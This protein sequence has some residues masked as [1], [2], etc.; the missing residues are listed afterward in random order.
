MT[1]DTL[2]TRLLA[3]LDEELPAAIELRHTLHANPEL[4]G[5]EH[6]TGQ[7]I[8]DALD[9][10]QLT[11]VAGTGLLGRVEGVG[12]RSV[13]VRAEL[14]GLPIQEATLAPF[15]ASNGYMHACGHDVH[16]AAL[17]AL[18]RAARR[19]PELPATLVALFQ[20]SEEAIPSGALG[21]V[22]SNALRALR[23]GAMV[24][25][26]VHPGLPWGKTAVT[27]GV[28]NAS[29]DNFRIRIKGSTGHAAYPHLARDPIVAL[30]QVIVSLQQIVSRRLDPMTNAVITIGWIKAGSAN[31]VIPETAEAG[32][33]LRTLQPAIRS[34]LQSLVTTT[35][36]QTARAHGC[37]AAITFEE[38]EPSLVNDQT[39]ADSVGRLVNQVG[40]ARGAEMRSCGADDFAYFAEVA[41]TLMMFVGVR[42]GRSVPLH[43]P[44]FLPPD[45][46][47]AEVARAQL[48]AYL[49][50]CMRIAK[51][52]ARE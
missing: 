43:H 16:M 6:A 31:N 47:V 20:P 33:T 12:S 19:V 29:A 5:A 11:S 2:M 36:R 10:V 17:T 42:R 8:A 9:P 41:P 1:E 27:A 46:A 32:G 25:V 51:F 26:H 38:G 49:G 34:Q 21:V 44:R 7:A 3:A 13:V 14:D 23:M 35:A 50:G 15:A 40:L 37:D 39:L 18:F 22:R 48:A 30:S 4:S 52:Q 28:V 45:E 24:G